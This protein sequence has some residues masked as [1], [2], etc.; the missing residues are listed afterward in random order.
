MGLIFLA[1][2]F[3]LSKD[4]SQIQQ[5]NAL[6][7]GDPLLPLKKTLQNSIMDDALSPIKNASINEAFDFLAIKNSALNMHFGNRATINHRLG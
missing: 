6:R 4:P 5:F 7:S 2:V 1:A 3:N